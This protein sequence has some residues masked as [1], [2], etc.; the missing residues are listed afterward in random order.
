MNRDFF[1]KVYMEIACDSADT[2]ALINASYPRPNEK[3]LQCCTCS[4]YP[5][6]TWKIPSYTFLQSC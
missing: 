5:T 4:S 1:E 2:I 3:A 6:N